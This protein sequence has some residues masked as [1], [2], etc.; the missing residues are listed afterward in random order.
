MKSIYA[1]LIILILLINNGGRLF[2]Q[3]KENNLTV[4]IGYPDLLNIGLRIKIFDK[5]KAGLIIGYWPPS[6]SGLIDWNSLLSLSGNFYYHFG[7]SSKFSST[8]PWY[9]R[10]DFNN[11]WE[12]GGNGAWGWSSDLRIGR[13]FNIDKTF[14]IYLELGLGYN[15][16][17]QEIRGSRLYQC[18]AGGFFIKLW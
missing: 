13:D 4:G 18:F 17:P 15:I 14:G 7:S 3:N 11:T 10:A 6:Y 2:G 16:E 8:A 1:V 9:G 5:A 12:S